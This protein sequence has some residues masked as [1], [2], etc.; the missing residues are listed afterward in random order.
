LY[1]DFIPISVQQKINGLIPPRVCF[2]NDTLAWGCTSDGCFSTKSA[3]LSTHVSI[4]HPNQNLFNLVWKWKGPE[5]IKLFLW[6]ATHACLMT[7]M[8]RFRRRMTTSKVCSRC[9]LHDE[10][11]LH[12]FRDCR[13]SISIW[14]NVNVQNRRSFFQERDWHQWLL[15]NLSGVIGSKDKVSW[16]LKFG[17]ILDKIWFAR[18]SFIF[19]H[20]ELNTFTILAQV[21]SM[22]QCLNLN[23][24]NSIFRQMSYSIAIKWERPTAD[25]IALSCDG[26]VTGQTGS[27]G[28]GGVLRNCNGVFL[29][30]F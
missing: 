12:V 10:S 8:E 25:F 2:R 17:I 20:K 26:A 7:N 11:L 3:Y 13:S 18:N 29:A 30:A 9:N 21:A 5:R 27:A 6:K 15:T 19:S 24:E 16:T 23:I 14:Q 4:N 28:C 22:M 1:E